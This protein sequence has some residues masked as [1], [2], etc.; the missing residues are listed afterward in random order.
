MKGKR[1]KSAELIEEAKI[2]KENIKNIPNAITLSR[3]VLSI[4]LII[5]ALNGSSLWTILVVFAIAA[6]TDAADGFTARK[7]NRVTNFGRRFDLIADR[8][9]TI[10][11]IASLLVYMPV[12]T[13]LT[14]EKL[15]L[16]LIIMSREIISAPFFIASLFIK[17]ARRMPHSR[18]IGKITTLFQGISF[19]LVIFGWSLAY[20]PAIIT[21][22]LGIATS[23]YFIYDSLINP[24]NAVQEKLDRHYAELEKRNLQASKSSKGL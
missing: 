20:I 16:I 4:V 23:C 11:I 24:N 21:A 1:K 18:L 19:P 7:F 15:I 10:S 22:L 6:L 8:F 14:Q 5:I 13:S 2:L 9:L 3:V 17:K 12:R